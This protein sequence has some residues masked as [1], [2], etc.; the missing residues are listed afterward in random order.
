MTYRKCDVTVETPR[1]RIFLPSKFAAITRDPKKDGPA[2]T[3]AEQLG[4]E[5]D[6][7]AECY[8]TSEESAADDM[9]KLGCDVFDRILSGYKRMIQQATSCKIE[10]AHGVEEIMRL[11]YSTLDHLDKRRFYQVARE[12][13][14]ALKQL[15]VLDP[16]TW[17]FT[18]GL[19]TID[20]DG[21]VIDQRSN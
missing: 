8:R 21:N 17:A 19:T 2:R 10:E 5:W 12:S 7:E 20:R 11:E 1:F 6:G 9:E 18:M 14:V 3:R 13:Y 15:E 16:E 4:L